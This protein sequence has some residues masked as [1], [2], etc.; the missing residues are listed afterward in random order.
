MTVILPWRNAT[1]FKGNTAASYMVG[2]QHIIYLGSLSWPK[3]ANQ[4]L[5][6][7]PALRIQLRRFM[8]AANVEPILV[9]GIETRHDHHTESKNCPVEQRG[10]A[11]ELRACM[12][13]SQGGDRNHRRYHHRSDLSPAAPST[14][15]ERH[16]LMLPMRDLATGARAKWLDW[17]RREVKGFGVSLCHL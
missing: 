4:A 7:A 9:Q 14:Q 12:Q 10:S 16:N 15:K 3:H 6:I 13:D 1:G 8:Q 2:T 17:K 11:P 5:I